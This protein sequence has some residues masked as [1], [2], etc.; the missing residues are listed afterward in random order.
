MSA[1]FDFLKDEELRLEENVKIQREIISLKT[2]FYKIYESIAKPNDSVKL[3][4][5]KKSNIVSKID[6]LLNDI[7]QLGELEN[8]TI[9]E[10]Y[11]FINLQKKD[12]KSCR[13]FDSLDKYI[14]DFDEEL[15]KIISSVKK[16]LHIVQLKNFSDESRKY[17][18]ILNKKIEL[19]NE[20]I[21]NFNQFIEKEKNTNTHDIYDLAV[22]KYS[23]RSYGYRVVF[24]VLMILV[25]I[26]V[27]FSAVLKKSLGLDQYDYWFFKIT[28]AITSITLIT[29][30]LRLST[31][32]QNIADQCEQTK[33]E[34]EA[35][36]SFVASF[37]TED[38]KIVEI[39]KE[40][41]MKYF[42]RDLL[43]NDKGEAS[44]IIT[45]Q[46]K[47]TTE[48]VKATTEAVKNLNA[49]TGGSSGS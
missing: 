25:V 45:D 5:E 29:F 27:W 14:N 18:K 44:N 10:I 48:L 20:S 37:S 36:P 7:A 40:L 4:E 22:K 41:A 9:R 30:Y 33:L 3:I 31:K 2:L 32:Y 47:N 42:G 28:L 23:N 39:R 24:L 1:E 13:T 38:P 19:Q 17:I 34:L 49:K 15:K 11:D 16:S 35:F 6:E 8:S 43:N 21:Q 46:M 26:L 12:L